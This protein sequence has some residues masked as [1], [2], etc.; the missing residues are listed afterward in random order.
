MIFITY[1]PCAIEFSKSEFI[2]VFFDVIFSFGYELR[3][4]VVG[5]TDVYVY[6]IFY[7]N[8]YYL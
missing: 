1:L 8:F 2:S 7:L 6:P 4:K 3:F 5:G